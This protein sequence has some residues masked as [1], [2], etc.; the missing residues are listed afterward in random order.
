MTIILGAKLVACV[1]GGILSR[2]RD[3]REAMADEPP[4]PLAVPSH[5][6]RDFTARI[7]SPLSKFYVAREQSRQLRRLVCKYSFVCKAVKDNNLQLISASR[8]K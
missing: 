1:A 7:H 8:L 6:P 3:Q 4:M 2:E 5:S